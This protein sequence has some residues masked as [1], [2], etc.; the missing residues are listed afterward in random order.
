MTGQTAEPGADG[1]RRSADWWATS[2][3]RMAPGVVE[4]RDRFSGERSEVPLGDVVEAVRAAV[5]S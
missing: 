2:V 4:L 3:S 1:E 5:S